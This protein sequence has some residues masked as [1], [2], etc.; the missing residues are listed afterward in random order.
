M[1]IALEKNVLFKEMKKFIEESYKPKQVKRSRR[2]K[3]SMPLPLVSP[4]ILWSIC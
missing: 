1:R 4:R 3:L 2:P